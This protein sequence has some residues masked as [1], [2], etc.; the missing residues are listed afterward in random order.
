MRIYLLILV[1]WCFGI[2]TIAQASNAFDTRTDVICQFELDKVPKISHFEGMIYLRIGNQRFFVAH[3]RLPHLQNLNESPEFFIRIP[4]NLKQK[5]LAAC[6]NYDQK[7]EI[8]YLAE[9]KD[10]LLYIN[11]ADGKPIKATAIN[12]E[13]L[14]ALKPRAKYQ[15]L[16][17]NTQASE[18]TST[19][20]LEKEGK[21][22]VLYLDYNGSTFFVDYSNYQNINT[23]SS[24][25]CV[26]FDGSRSTAYEVIKKGEEIQILNDGELV[27]S[28][29]P[30]SSK[31]T[32]PKKL[33]DDK[34]AQFAIQKINNESHL[35]LLFDT[36]VFPIYQLPGN[37]KLKIE[38]PDKNHIVAQGSYQ[39]P[40][41]HPRIFQAKWLGNEIVVLDSEK[42][43]HYIIALETEKADI[44]PPP[45]AEKEAT[46][47]WANSRVGGFDFQHPFRD[48]F[49]QEGGR[50]FFTMVQ[51]F[52][53]IIE[54]NCLS[55][56][57]FP[58]LDRKIQ[59][60]R[61]ASIEGMVFLQGELESENGIH[62]FYKTIHRGQGIT[63]I[64][65]LNGRD[66]TQEVAEKILST[67]KV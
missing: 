33:S 10:N 56:T 7:S 67:L 5:S 45:Q 11:S 58:K 66:V 37:G 26:L 50:N 25:S 22:T 60:K 49:L 63:F 2:F 65:H 18:S 47:D 29:R 15:P 19:F 44:A 3:T 52:D 53:V 9:I 54:P 30:G 39:L 59:R 43:E 27:K 12:P 16:T 46:P 41:R 20:R 17:E 1:W 51:K 13:T 64:F 8:F 57:S 62:L 42:K 40:Q 48:R 61:M 38:S 35:C 14:E 34:Y 24:S 21:N 32:R 28:V 55:E 36:Q 6:V 4:S 23:T 31:K